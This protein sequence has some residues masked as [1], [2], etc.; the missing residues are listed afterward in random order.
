[1]A[2]SERFYTGDEVVGLNKDNFLEII[3]Y[4][5]SEDLI[6]INFVREGNSFW[7]CAPGVPV[8]ELKEK[9]QAYTASSVVDS[10]ALLFDK[11][12]VDVVSVTLEGAKID[13]VF[14][15]Q[16]LLGELVQNV[17]LKRV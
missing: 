11:S 9:C 10:G 1:M 15:L 12:D 6:G 16:A 13:S 8:S 14:L 7:I 5:I 3:S 4:L 17:N 2:M